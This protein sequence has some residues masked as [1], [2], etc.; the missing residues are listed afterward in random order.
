MSD[1]KSLIISS[2]FSVALVIIGNNY[3]QSLEREKMISEYLK[4]L[5][6]KNSPAYTQSVALVALYRLH[7][8]PDDLIFAIGCRGPAI[9]PTQVQKNSPVRAKLIPHPG[10]E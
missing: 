2:I 1:F 6:D 4:T 9:I 10:P 7:K 8:M 5:N 3:T